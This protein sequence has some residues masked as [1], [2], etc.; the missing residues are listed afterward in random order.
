MVNV[1]DENLIE[2]GKVKDYYSSIDKAVY[3]FLSRAIW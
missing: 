2:I 3:I 1:L